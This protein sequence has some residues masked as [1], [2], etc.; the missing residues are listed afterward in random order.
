MFN[1]LLVSLFVFYTIKRRTKLIKT[2]KKY[3]L[4]KTWKERAFAK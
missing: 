3:E 4:S 1:Q 2:P